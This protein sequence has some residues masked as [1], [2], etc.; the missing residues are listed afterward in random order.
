MM[1]AWL[2]VDEA[3]W[4]HEVSVKKP[5]VIKENK[6]AIIGTMLFKRADIFK[7]GY[8]YIRQHQIQ[9]NG[10]YYVDDLLNPLII[11]GYRVKVFPV[12]Y[13]LCWGTPNDYKTYL[14]WESFF[15][16]CEWHPYQRESE[17]KSITN[18][19]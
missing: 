6:H 9:T 14:Y 7:K 15:H 5:L 18:I 19:S 1:Y 11:M 4:I 17:Y 16:K 10:E 3:G 8:Q 12:D 13:Y 2:D